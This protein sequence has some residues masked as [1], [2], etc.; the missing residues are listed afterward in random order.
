[1]AS[2]S[3]AYV[4]NQWLTCQSK[5][6]AEMHYVDHRILYIVCAGGVTGAETMPGLY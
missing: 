1:M 6:R 3:P 4:G 5:A 2:G